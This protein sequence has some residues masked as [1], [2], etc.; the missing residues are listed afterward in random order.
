MLAFTKC[1]DSRLNR[2]HVVQS[3]RQIADPMNGHGS[4]VAG[5]I[6]VRAINGIEGVGVASEEQTRAVEAAQYF[7]ASVLRLFRGG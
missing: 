3:D 2:V 1:T 7:L 5:M 4:R 6:A